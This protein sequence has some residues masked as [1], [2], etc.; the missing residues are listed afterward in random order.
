MNGERR[1][2]DLQP[3]SYLMARGYKFIRAEG[4]THK[5]TFIFVGVPDEDV[6]SIYAGDD[7]VSAWHLFDG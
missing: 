4:P 7:Q 3:A 1:I 6:F 2:S 5:R